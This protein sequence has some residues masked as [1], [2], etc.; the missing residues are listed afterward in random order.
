MRIW[1]FAMVIIVGAV[2]CGGSKKGTKTPATES[3]KDD[4]EGGERDATQPDD[5]DDMPSPSSEDPMGDGGA[6]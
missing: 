1:L 3:D 6:D 4:A 2:G 5:A